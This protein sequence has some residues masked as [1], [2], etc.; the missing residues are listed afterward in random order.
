[1]LPTQLLG[2]SDMDQNQ[3]T[4]YQNARVTT[5]KNII[6]ARETFSRANIRYI[7]YV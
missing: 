4:I 5:V 1:M 2:E 3:N 7:Y 6:V